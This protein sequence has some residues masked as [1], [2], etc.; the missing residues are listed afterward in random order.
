MKRH[1]FQ[2]DSTH[3]I[4]GGCVRLTRA[5]IFPTQSLHVT[6]SSFIAVLFIIRPYPQ[7][8]QDDPQDLE[9]MWSRRIAESGC[10]SG[11]FAS[12]G[13]RIPVF[14]ESVSCF[15]FNKE[16]V[17]QTSWVQVYS[18]CKMPRR[19]P[20][21]DFT[22]V[23]SWQWRASTDTKS[24]STLDVNVCLCRGHTDRY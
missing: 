17:W 18:A 23:G 12:A 7:A 5:G 21:A 10:P 6:D 11:A 22:S 8:L 20:T 9:I 13:P 15:G 3:R 1:D 16:Q 14:L 19:G 2:E 24:L 4:L